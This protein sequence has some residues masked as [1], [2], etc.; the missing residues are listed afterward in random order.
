MTQEEIRTRGID[1]LRRELGAVGMLRFLRQFDQGKGDYT[2]ERHRWL[3]RLTIDDIF[4]DARS[5]RRARKQKT[6]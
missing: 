3:D 1:V 2:K 5:L 4:K 6:V